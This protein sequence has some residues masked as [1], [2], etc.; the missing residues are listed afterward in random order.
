MVKIIVIAGGIGAGKTAV[1]D[2]LRGRGFMV[3]DADL[4][5][6]KV[7]EPGQP[8]LRALRDAFGDAILDHE[9]R[10]DRVFMADVVFH[11]PTAL[12]RLNALTHG[13][14]GAEIANE[15][16]R[17]R[18]RGVFI[19]LP[20]FRPEH[21][22]LFNVNEVW[23]VHVDP[24]TALERLVTRRGLHERDARARLENQMTNDERTRI[25]DRVISNDGSLN[26]LHARLEQLLVESGL[27][28]G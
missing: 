23:A 10:L 15:L 4:I 17:A 16:A 13:Y 28:D 26:E 9:G 18:G 11:D 20:L 1:T 19:A 8:A 22:V 27:N 21:R 12:R 14:I 6:H 3:V 5:A 25:V 24:E 7:V 2:W